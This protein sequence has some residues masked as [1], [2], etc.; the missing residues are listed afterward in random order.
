MGLFA[1]S[2]YI[3]SD[4]LLSDGGFIFTTVVLH[5]ETV[6]ADKTVVDGDLFQY[7]YK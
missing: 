2:S 1:V 4:K 3:T 5:L 7:V 6:G